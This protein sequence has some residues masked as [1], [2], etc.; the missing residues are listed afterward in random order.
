MLLLLIPAFARGQQHLPDSTIRALKLASNDSSRFASNFN[1]AQYF[2]EINKDS[3][4]FYNEK[5]LSL[6][7]KNNLKLTMARALANK[8]YLLTGKA[9]YAEALNNLLRAFAIAEDP[10]NASRRWF[11]NQKLTGEQSRLFVLAL[12]HHM[13]AILMRATQ[14]MEQVV[15]HFKEARRIALII[16]HKIRVMLAA[17]NLGEAYLAL[18]KADSA[19]VFLNEAKKLALETGQKGYFGIILAGFGDIALEKGDKA[20]AKSFYYEGVSSAIVV[21]NQVAAVRLYT[22]LATFYLAEKDRDSSLY[23]AQK[24]L[25][26]SLTLGMRSSQ[27][28]NIGTAYEKLYESYKLRG[29]ADSAYKY[30]R[31]ALAENDSINTIRVE[32]LARFQSLSLKE[33][34]RLQNL[35]K[36]KVLYQSRVRIYALL[37]GLGIFLVIGAILWRN[38]QRQKHTNLLLHEQKEEIEAQ[39]DNLEHHN[40]ELEIEAALERVRTVAMG[41]SKA[42]DMLE[43][44]KTI[45]Q[46]LELLGL[47]EIRNVQTAIFYKERGT[48]MNYEHY[49]RHDKNIITETSYVNNKKHAEFAEKMQKGYGQFFDLHIPRAELKD[50]LTYQKTTNVFIDTHLE[51]AASLSYYWYSLAAVALGISTYVPLKEEEKILFKR[52]LKVFELSYKR[53]LDIKQAEEQAREAQ[54]EAALERTRTQSMIMQ[55]SN[56]LDDTLRVFHE[57]VL[58]LGIDSAFSFLWLPDEE[59]DRHIFWAAWA[60]NDSKTFKSKA[61]DYP[62]DRN[63]P[64]TAQCLI[65]WKGNDPVVAYH[66]PPEGVEGY[67]AAW[68]E[69]IDG[70]EQLKP[71]YFSGGLYYVEAFMKYGCFGIIVK[72]E[73]PEEQKKILARFAIEFERTYTRFLDL[74]KAEAQAREAQIEAALE[75]VR[76]RT[77]AMHNSQDV[78]DTSVTM[79]QELVK[80]GVESTV[81]C[82]VSIISNE[83]ELEVWTAS[84]KDDGSIT[85]NTGRLTMTA[86]PLLLHVF[87]AWQNKESSTTYEL[88]GEALRSYFQ[89]LNDAPGY[90]FQYP[91]DSLPEKWGIN[92]FFFPEGCL[93]AFTGEPLS[94]EMSQLFKRFAGVFGQTYRRY[95][96]LKKAEAQARE[97]KIEAAMEKVRSRSLAMQKP[98]ELV[99]VARL[100]RYEMALLGVEELETSSIYI[101]HEATGKTECWYAIKDDQAE[102]KLVADHMDMDLDET[103]VGRQMLAFYHS[104]KKQISILMQGE[105]RKEW[106]N[107]CSTKSKLLN[108]FYGDNIPDRTYHLNKFSNGYMGAASPCDISAESWELLQRATAVFSFAYTRFSDLQQAEAQA[109]E[110]QIETGLERVRSRTM[111]MQASDELAETAAVVFKQLIGLGIAPNR[112]FI[113]II[114]DEGEDIELWATEEDGSK[115]STRFTGKISR[116]A[117]VKKMYDGWKHKKKSITI[118]MSGKELKEYFHYLAEELKVPFKLGLTQ[119]RRVQSVA[120]FSKGFIG[121]ASPDE[122]PEETIKLLERFAGVFNL[123]FIRFHD[124]KIAEAHAIQAEQDL[125]LLQTEKRRAEDALTELKSTQT[126]LVQREKM[127]SLGELTAG[128]AH[129]IQN[130]LNFVNN[131]SEVSRELMAE[132]IEELDNGDTEEAKAITQD[133]I[134]NLAKINH[135]G[136]RADSIVKGMLEH[137]RVGTGQKQPT[138]LNTLAD[139]FLKLSYHGLRA[140]D[141]SFNA[142][143]VTHYD[144]AL[145]KANVVQQDIGRVLINLFNNAFYAVNQKLKTATADY[146]PTVE[147]ST[148]TQNGQAIIKIKD[149]GTG[150][151]DAIKEKI[152]QP[153]FTTKPTGEGTGLGLSLSYDILVKG[154]NGTLDIISKEGEGSEFIVKLPV[155]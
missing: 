124:L 6:A 118:D 59:K 43:V 81:R 84:L 113:G 96:D 94:P 29:Q 61:I 2:Q 48:Y 95:L 111:A 112:L 130:P 9:E 78:A 21:N 38:Y 13:Y 133:V 31:L 67:F 131:F 107:Y 99:E 33:Q 154:H 24:M 88:T 16:P 89:A 4:L 1:A 117:S 50:W 151:P 62:L 10:K 152:L 132:L 37:A 142:D 40:R 109:R 138:D 30:S 125:I 17:M 36:Q 19:A 146:K 23:F 22:K 126:Q 97:A 70:V 75:R 144:T 123:T 51:N 53:Y 136:R 141:K 3:A 87:N 145:L 12:T 20:K 148:S 80:L 135:H 5:C 122:Q 147:V 121:M 115:I 71:E 153:F 63:E 26:T 120:Y 83:K 129:E 25:Q 46:Q 14:N 116:N 44:C 86:H 69:L 35:E 64:A 72:N 15:F 47:K 65:D 45:S 139:E 32:N 103:W 119:K 85:L 68:Q 127:A 90:P 39:R 76:S 34:L 143:L 57:Q 8:G 27:T 91:M 101:H 73:L 155:N 42:D 49:A 28:A 93:F 52:F 104:A 137:S 106:I 92:A 11:T 128:I 82:G 110:A 7:E 108:G 149:N 66:V 100:L 77:M 102:H 98:G 56:E 60:E 150:I 54:I 41:M 105:N 114:P 134:E 140:K 79:F 18:K 58:H 74:Q 55:H